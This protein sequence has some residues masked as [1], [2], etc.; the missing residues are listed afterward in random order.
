MKKE[1]WSWVAGGLLFAM[2]VGVWFWQLPT[3]IKSTAGNGDNGLSGITAVIGGA[4]KD[5]SAD[6]EKAQEKLKTSM[7][8]IEEAVK[9]ETIEPNV[10]AEMKQKINNRNEVKAA[11]LVNPDPVLKTAEPAP[12]TR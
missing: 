12:V 11:T 10:V 6:L 9:E 4:K 3:I 8:G 2:I 5:I 7:Q 1:T